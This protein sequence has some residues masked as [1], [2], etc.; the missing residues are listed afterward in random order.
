MGMKVDVKVLAGWVFCLSLVGVLLLVFVPFIGWNWT[1]DVGRAICE[2]FSLC[3]EADVAPAVARLEGVGIDHL[4]DCQLH[5][6]ERCEG[7]R[8]TGDSTVKVLVSGGL[9]G[10]DGLLLSEGFSGRELQ[11]MEL[12]SQRG[13][14]YGA[15]YCAYGSGSLEEL[16]PVIRDLPEG[17]LVLVTAELRWGPDSKRFITYDDDG[18]PACRLV[19]LDGSRWAE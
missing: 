16:S 11:Y 15:L 1:G 14:E 5:G 4:L 8:T 12:V 18:D 9:Y 13:A 10:G 3:R 6:L 17:A 2:P 7:L 19:L